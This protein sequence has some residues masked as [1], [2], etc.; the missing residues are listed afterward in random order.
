VSTNPETKISGLFII[1]LARKQALNKQLF[2][3]C[4]QAGAKVLAESSVKKLVKPGSSKARNS[5]SSH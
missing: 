5:I 2:P 4:R 1:I 3:V